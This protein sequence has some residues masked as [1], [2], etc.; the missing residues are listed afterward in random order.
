MDK[1]E[2]FASRF[3]ALAEMDRS[4]DEAA[5]IEEENRRKDQQ[6]RLANTRKRRRYAL[7]SMVEKF[8]SDL[9][10]W[11]IERLEVLLQ[12]IFS[13]EET[14]EIMERLAPRAGEAL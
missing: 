4:I 10:G 11:E 7:G 13:L 2:Y 6:R 1:E 3:K 5:M 12:E 14:R 8:V 9:S